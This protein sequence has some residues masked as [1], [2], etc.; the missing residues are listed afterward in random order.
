MLLSKYTA[1]IYNYLRNRRKKQYLMWHGW[2][3]IV[4][5]YGIKKI[6]FN[7]INLY[8]SLTQADWNKVN[9]PL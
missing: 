1:E 9:M 4:W 2:I 5:G 8:V 6:S 3:H 7:E